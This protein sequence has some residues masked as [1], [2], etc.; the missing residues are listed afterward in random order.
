MC[1]FFLQLTRYNSIEYYAFI[2]VSKNYL[3]K[4][5]HQNDLYFCYSPLRVGEGGLIF[6]RIEIQ[7]AENL[8][9]NRVFRS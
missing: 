1:I 6:K 4:F 2:H 7:R 5:I 8:F 3:I 9:N